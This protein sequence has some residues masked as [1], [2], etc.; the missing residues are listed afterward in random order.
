MIVF[1]DYVCHWVSAMTGGE[2]HGGGRGIGLEKNGDLVA[3]V[4]YDNFNGKSICM[5]VAGVGSWL[6]R[7]YL[8]VCFDYPFNRLKVVKLIGIVDGG[9]HKS[10]R[11][12][13]HLGFVQEAIIKDA[14]RSMDLHIW[15]M[16][17]EQCRYIG[18]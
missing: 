7:E 8:K 10:M 17:R 16:T 11:F 9:N 13:R 3:G 5:H 12:V 6:N 4:L 18:E 1:G 14:G 2:Y 15:T